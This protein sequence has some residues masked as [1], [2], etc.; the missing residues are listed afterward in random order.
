MKNS[1]H[2]SQLLLLDNVVYVFLFFV[3]IYLI[4]KKLHDFP[5][6]VSTCHVSERR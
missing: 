1:E 3:V 4:I 2:V 5:S 6:E